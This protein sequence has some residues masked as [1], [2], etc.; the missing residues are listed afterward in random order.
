[1]WRGIPNKGSP[2]ECL[3]FICTNLNIKSTIHSWVFLSYDMQLFTSDTTIFSKKGEK[4][5]S[6]VAYFMILVK[7]F[8]ANNRPKTRRNI[9][10][11]S[12]TIAHFT[13]NE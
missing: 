1:M 11:C 13:T 8:R 10:F 7:N 3:K 5:P 4:L 9:N 2:I 6:K 12:I